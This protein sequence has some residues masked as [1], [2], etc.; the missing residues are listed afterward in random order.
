MVFLNGKGFEQIEE[1]V[2]K[3][4]DEK[5]INSVFGVKVFVSIPL[6]YLLKLFDINVK[7]TTVLIISVKVVNIYV[8]VNKPDVSDDNTNFIIRTA[9]VYQGY[10]T[11]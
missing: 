8:A 6:Y 10:L 2:N 4:I 1:V 5:I 9:L 7:R 3:K 11:S